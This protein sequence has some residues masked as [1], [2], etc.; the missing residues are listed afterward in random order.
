MTNRKKGRTLVCAAVMLALVSGLSAG[1][2]SLKTEHD[3]KPI[4]ITM[5]INLKIDRQLDTYLDDIYGEA[6]AAEAPATQK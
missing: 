2:M 3:I 5:D 1:C 6:P 4:H